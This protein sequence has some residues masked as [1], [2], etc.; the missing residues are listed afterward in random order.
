M[1]HQTSQTP[2][3]P[4]EPSP[5]QKRGSEGLVRQLRYTFLALTLGPLFVAALISIGSTRIALERQ[6]SQG[7]TTSA[8][9][10][11]LI[12]SSYIRN[13]TDGL[14]LFSQARDLGNL[15]DTAL[16]DALCSLFDQFPGA[17]T[18]IVLLDTSGQELAQGPPFLARQASEPVSWKGTDVFAAVSKGQNH[19]ASQPASETEVLS[20]TTAGVPVRDRQD[21]IVG[22]LVATLDPHQMW[23]EISQIKVGQSGYVYVI[24]RHGKLVAYHE[25]EQP[26][27]SEVLVQVAGVKAFTGETSP[28][29]RI[30]GVYEGLLEKAVVGAY[31]PVAGTPWAVV[32]ES[33]TKE[34]FSALRP[35]TL[36][37]VILFA[38]AAV[39]AIGA[40]SVLANRIVEPVLRLR[41]N[42]LAM[43]AGDL[44]RT[45]EIHTGDEIEEL[46]KAF[47]RMAQSLQESRAEREAWAHELENQVA[48]RTREL[49]EMVDRQGFLLRTIWELSVPVVTVME[50]V[51]VMPLVGLIDAARGRQVVESLT[52]GLKKH[53]ARFVI[54]DITGVPEVDEEVAGYLL[55]ATRMARLLGAEPILVGVTP[56]VAQALVDLRADLGR[57]ATRTDLQAGV[58]Y[59]RQAIHRQQFS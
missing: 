59:A 50:G 8:T 41:D 24:D 39:L 44:N 45:I 53:N 40:S 18:Q 33:P 19:I 2:S 7:Q 35:M 9:E 4:S 52:E 12:V 14:A 56:A 31:A 55:R 51:I 5:H 25:L 16:L 32:V 58:E 48:D 42:A 49:Q 15:K 10:A 34:A 11:S 17:L 20:V 26:V 21:K 36:V 23:H 28:S 27:R 46:G 47:N 54:L 43:G 29:A 3:E 57:I 30:V 37:F 6:V 13:L 1:T 22:L 38:L